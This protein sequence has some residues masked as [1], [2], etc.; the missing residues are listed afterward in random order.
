LWIQ[1]LT[2]LYRYDP[3]INDWIAYATTPGYALAEWDEKL[4][5]LDTTNTMQYIVDA[6]MTGGWTPNGK[7]RLPPGY[8]Q[9]LIPF[10][11]LAGDTVLHAITRVGVY[12]Y[13][14]AAGKFY[15]TPMT[16]PLSATPGKGAIV[17]RGELYIPTNEFIYKYNGS[18]ITAVSPN[19]DDGLPPELRGDIATLVAGHSF[20]YAVISTKQAN[21]IQAIH[22]LLFDEVDVATTDPVLFNESSWID[23]FPL[24]ATTTTGGIMVS[25]GA[26]WHGV[27]EKVAGTDMGAATVATVQG[28]FRLWFSDGTG[29]YYIAQDTGLHNPFQNRTVDYR[30]DGRIEWGWTAIGFENMDKLALTLEVFAQQVDAENTIDIFVAWDDVDQWE[31]ILHLTESGRVKIALNGTAGKVFRRVRFA[32]EMHRALNPDEAAAWN[33]AHPDL[34]PKVGVPLAEHNTPLMPNMTLSFVRRPP[35]LWGWDVDIPI[36]GMKAG[37]TSKDLVERLYEITQ[38]TKEAGILRYR[39]ENSGV[40]REHQ[41]MITNI[42]GAEPTGNEVVGRFTVSLV[43][44]DDEDISEW[45]A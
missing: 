13:D 2:S 35:F 1:T 43:Q 8:C 16:F 11:N 34:P 20:Y 24:T 21:V 32:V 44:L 33:L 18:T 6:V 36:T 26:A 31:Q 19:R 9:Q 42:Q 7:L 37:K 17:W 38:Q 4:Y 30:P 23:T 25:P 41:V 39:V 27:V 40:W 29:I 28:T 12:G 3:T 10:F 45:S 14:H 5:R 15:E 22:M